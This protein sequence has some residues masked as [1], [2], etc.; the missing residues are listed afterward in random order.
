[1]KPSRIKYDPY[2]SLEDIAVNSGVSVEAVRRY[3][4]NRRIDR[5]CDEEI[6]RYHK[7]KRKIK[8]NPHVT[9]PKISTSLSMAIGTVRKYAD[10]K[11]PPLP[12]HGKIS[13]VEQM[14][15]TLYVSVSESE[16][17]ILRAILFTYLN[18]TLTYDCDLTIGK[19]GFYQNSVPLPRFLYDINPLMDGVKNLSE[20][21][22]LP[23]EVFNSVVIDLPC[24]IVKP[25][26]RRKKQIFSSFGTIEELY[27]TYKKMIELA[28]RLLK[29][30]GILVFKTM[31]FSLNSEPL[32]ISDKSV[33]T[34]VQTGFSLIDKYIYID[35]KAVNAITSS[36]RRASTPAHAY[37]F[38]FKKRQII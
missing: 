38:V 11:R 9:I 17:E 18:N 7:V 16:S 33:A 27:A 1:M 29:D 12:S 24:A 34:A 4:K 5:K 22:N 28:W 25:T 37:F 2:L 21:I 36:R 35:R 14:Q 26:I 10:I 31:D 6:I 13:M 32:W 3:I 8:D 19:G 15:P 23:N 30:D 20:A